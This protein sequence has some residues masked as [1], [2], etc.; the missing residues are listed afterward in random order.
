MKQTSHLHG[1]Y[2]SVHGYIGIWIRTRHKIVDKRDCLSCPDGA[3]PLRVDMSQ[4]ADEI[5]NHTT[6]SKIITALKN[7]YPRVIETI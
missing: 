2:V 4:P 6:Q 1:Y 3:A 5:R 7:I